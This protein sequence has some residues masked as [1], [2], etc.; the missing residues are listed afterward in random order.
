MNNR[1][2]AISYLKLIFWGALA[3]GI[4]F[5][6]SA[7][8]ISCKKS[9]E[10]PVPAPPIISSFSPTSGI[11]PDGGLS[12]TLITISGS[13]FSTVPV[14][15]E[16]KFN[17]T[18]ATTNTASNT[19]LTASVP[20][21]ATKGKISVTT[22]GQTGT[23]ATDFTVNTISPPNVTITIT[24]F[25]PTSGLIGTTVTITGTNFNSTTSLNT[26]KFNNIAATI[27]A[28]TSTQLTVTVPAAATTG[29]ITVTANGLTSTSSSDFVVVQPP[30]ITSFAPNAAVVGATVT[31]T[32][33]NFNA[34]PASNLVQ[35]NSISATVMSASTTQLT[36]TVPLATTG[37]IDI[38][39]NGVTISSALD[40]TVLPSPTI[41]NFTPLSALPGASL[42]IEGTNFKT[43]TN[44]NTVKING[45]LATV[46]ASTSTQ[47]TVTIP[48]AATTGK[49][50]V[51][52]NGAT[53]TSVS[54]F[55]VLKD[56]PRNGLMFYYPFNNGFEEVLQGTFNFVSFSPTPPTFIQDR[57][58]KNQQAINLDGSQFATVPGKV[59]PNVPWT[60]SFWMKYSSLTGTVGIMSSMASSIGLEAFLSPIGTGYVIDIYGRNAGPITYLSSGNLSQG[61][62]STTIGWSNITITYDGNT[63]IIYNNGTIVDQTTKSFIIGASFQFI[64]CR[65][66]GINFNGQMDDLIVYDRVL[67]SQEVTQLVQQ[68]VSKY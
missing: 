9:T 14:E 26:V 48:A 51:E 50:T 18:T 40:F 34:T 38:T 36:V 35:F 59:I 24:S 56:I 53:A 64:F 33:T 4:V 63:C 29:K 68:T 23:S 8:L 60:I 1:V 13:N 45:T 17:G 55:E 43:I 2:T 12:G 31:I 6:I 62:L 21:G 28:A 22:N 10:E 25:N 5:L 15:N 19:Q 67:S 42:V 54:D 37:K 39:V 47:L 49:V 52:L 44:E 46:T 58:S 3:V 57:F 30:T 20:A 11:P 41:T 61:Y 65:S 27:N 66:T 16:I 32:G 7:V